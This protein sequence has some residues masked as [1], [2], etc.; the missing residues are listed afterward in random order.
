MSKIRIR[1]FHYLSV[2]AKA[3]EA[4]LNAL[5]Q[6]GW[7]FEGSFWGFARFSAVEAPAPRYC[8]DPCLNATWSSD[9]AGT[10]GYNDYIRLCADA[11]WELLEENSSLR[12][13]RSAPGADLP[14]IQTDPA[15]DYEANWDDILRRQQRNAILYIIMWGFNFYRL[16]RD[17]SRFTVLASPALLAIY[18][19][20]VGVV[21]AD[22]IYGVYLAR[23]RAQCRRAIA[24][25]GE[26]PA[27]TPMAAKIR[28]FAPIALFTVFVL[29][30]LLLFAGWPR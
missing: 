12:I 3:A 8:V 4:E 18:A 21:I 2:D 28:G 7:A 1:W 23:R 10:P 29:C 13:F 16:V 25:G 24:Q 11:G 27:S 6:K 17:E 14:P 22:I 20:L 15:L 30:F 9:S 26:L 19:L 5:A